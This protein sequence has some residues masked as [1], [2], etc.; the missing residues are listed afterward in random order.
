[1]K[2]LSGKVAVVTGAASGIGLALGERFA[3]EGMRVVLADIEAD[4]LREVA[5]RMLRAG[6]DVSSIRIDVSNSDGVEE[7]TGFALRQYGTVHVL[8]NDAGVGIG[9][10]LWEYTVKDWEWLLG[11]NLWGVIYG[12]RTFLPSCCARGPSA[13][14]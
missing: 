10:A 6:H 13:T 11:V 5:F 2:D 4:A 7:L 12:I 8:C 9:G 3:D 1:M 14:S